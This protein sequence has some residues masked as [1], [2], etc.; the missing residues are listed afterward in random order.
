M[1]NPARAQMLA[2]AALEEASMP[3]PVIKIE[4]S[5]PPPVSGANRD[6]VGDA[7][8]RALRDS[9]TNQ[10]QGSQP[11]TVVSVEDEGAPKAKLTTTTVIDL[12]NST[13]PSKV[14]DPVTP[15]KRPSNDTGGG[16]K[17]KKKKTKQAGYYTEILALGPAPRP[18]TNVEYLLSLLRN[19]TLTLC[20]QPPIKKGE[21]VSQSK[22]YEFQISQAALIQHEALSVLSDTR[23][24]PLSLHD[25]DI[26]AS[27]GAITRTVKGE[28]LED[29]WSSLNKQMKYQYA[30]QL[31]SWLHKLRGHPK[32]RGVGSVRSGR[33][34]LMLDKHPD[35]T[36]YA[37]REKPSQTQFMALLMSTMYDSVP[38]G[39]AQALVSQFRV[40]YPTVF[41]HG[42][43]CPK[44]IVV[45]N[46]TIVWILGW[47]CAG[48]Y[49]A[50]WEYAR[51]YEARTAEVNSDWY[52]Y[53]ADIFEEQFPT[54]LA[55]YQGLVRCQQP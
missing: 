47:D 55:V 4:S 29:I 25:Q 49:P 41:T 12:G 18:D 14:P 52:S 16:G 53:V 28:L 32:D 23:A 24:L 42:A 44:H 35:H 54:E 34:S 3:P 51:F 26:S 40:N 39:V 15:L 5:P 43:L 21:V 10:P 48:Y 11:A 8:L 31:R 36:Y 2:D 22:A 30:R 27:D 13:L 9:K 1:M 20:L 19:R 17:R 38:K 37:I 33:F 46:S 50:W 6:P 7:S 45:C